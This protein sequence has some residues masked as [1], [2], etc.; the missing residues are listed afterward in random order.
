MIRPI[1][2]N[3]PNAIPKWFNV[4]KHCAYHSGVQG[5]DTEDY[6]GLKNKVEALIKEGVI[7]LTRVQPNIHNNPLPNHGDASVNVILT[8]K[9]W[10]LEGTIIAIGDIE[11]SIIQEK[12]L[13]EVESLPRSISIMD[14]ASHEVSFHK[15][16]LPPKDFW[17]NKPLHIDNKYG[18]KFIS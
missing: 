8:E 2:G 15:S 14:N 13:I 18:N 11:K 16:E 4:S 3:I 12:T 1:E 17:H 7:Q 6:Y 10:N 9:E 5:H